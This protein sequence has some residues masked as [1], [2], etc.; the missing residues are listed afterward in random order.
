MHPYISHLME[1]IK[2]AYKE[3]ILKENNIPRSLEAHF[4]EISSLGKRR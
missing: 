2:N 1:N 3:D 4:E